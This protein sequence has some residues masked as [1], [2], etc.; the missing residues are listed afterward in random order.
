VGTRDPR[1]RPVILR[2]AE[3]Q[4][5]PRPWRPRPRTVL[6]VS[7][8][9]LLT[10]VGVIAGS[11]SVWSVVGP[12]TPPGNPAPPLWFSPPGLEITDHSSSTGDSST[13]RRPVENGAD[14]NPH[15][16]GSALT[17]TEDHSGPGATTTEDSSGHGR[18]ANNGEVDNSGPS[19]GGHG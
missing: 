3:A 6:G 11:W 18:G 13:G 4:Q 12:A 8:A 17:P 7:A 16:T 14:D 19:R 10:A 9:A 2:T 15:R 5:F 1:N